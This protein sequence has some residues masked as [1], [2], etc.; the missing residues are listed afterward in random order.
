MNPEP[1][2]SAVESSTSALPRMFLR[3]PGWHIKRKD[4]S[5]R[6]FCYTISPGR[7][8]YHRLND[9]ELYLMKGVEK[10]CIECASRRGL[11]LFEP[12]ILRDPVVGLG[13]DDPV[14]LADYEIGL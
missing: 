11:I 14:G 12:K 13:I 2:S 8:S 9:G 3:E 4:G 10:L 5:D 7:D 1:E 6:E